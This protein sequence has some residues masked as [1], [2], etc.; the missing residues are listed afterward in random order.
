MGEESIKESILLIQKRPLGEESIEESILLGLGAAFECVEPVNSSH[1]LEGRGQPV[2][3][4]CRNGD[5]VTRA[6]GRGG[7]VV[8][9]LFPAIGNVRDAAAR[10]NTTN[11]MKQIG[12]AHHMFADTNLGKLASPKHV[13]QGATQPVELSWRVTL[14]PYLEQ[15]V[16]S[17]ALNF[18]LGIADPSNLTVRGSTVSP[19]F[20]IIGPA[21]AVPQT[22][23]G[24]HGY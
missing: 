12:L 3:G 18:N 15:Q 11:N 24:R 14:L 10:T 2:D 13:P 7:L 20:G 1:V 23:S 4:V 16:L 22:R 21:F 5:Y 6:Q 19:V 9:L 8:L 17:N